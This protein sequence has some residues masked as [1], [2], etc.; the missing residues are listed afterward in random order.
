MPDNRLTPKA[1]K[2]LRSREPAFESP[3]EPSNLDL[4]R[5]LHLI[6]AEVQVLGKRFKLVQDERDRILGELGLTT[7][8]DKRWI[9]K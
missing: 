2:A 8:L 6:R 3:R 4:M 5:E 7:S 9:P 1:I